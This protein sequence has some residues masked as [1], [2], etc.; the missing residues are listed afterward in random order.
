MLISP[1]S[2]NTV[3]TY[4]DRLKQ[5]GGRSGGQLPEMHKTGRSLG[6]RFAELMDDPMVQMGQTDAVKDFLGIGDGKKG[7]DMSSIDSAIFGSM[8][9]TNVKAL[10]TLTR[11]LGDEQNPFASMFRGMGVPEG[12][13]L[14]MAVTPP[15][16]ASRSTMVSIMD[17]AATAVDGVG[18]TSGRTAFEASQAMQQAEHQAALGRADGSVAT[19]QAGQAQP[20]PH[21]EKTESVD[22]PSHLGAAAD[23]ERTPLGS[24]AALFESG[25][26]GGI[27]AIGYDRRGG[28]SYGKF[29]L[30]SRAGTM[31]AFIR[32]LDSHAPDM[33][34]HLK[35]A[36]RANT[37][38]RFG[39]MPTAWK[40]L[41]ASQPARFEQLQDSFIHSNNFY[42]AFKAVS[43]A[44]Q[45]DDMNPALQEVLFSTAVQHGPTGAVRIFA[46]AFGRTGGYVDGM[47][48]D[49]IRN[50]YRVRQG[51]FDSS[52]SGVQT[53]VRG[54]LGDELRMALS[55]LE[56]TDMA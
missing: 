32:Y 28:T 38:S 53:A 15:P 44:M 9:L 1:I 46:K 8:D 31:D 25:A 23:S 14:R 4:L 56:Q 10:A 33:A 45:L 41:A 18:D 11:V 20:V 42:P 29:Q 6:S 16:V 24:L 22:S 51:Q 13:E 30:S 26:D 3:T 17:Q 5:G 43:R 52:S 27:Q 36:G 47:E 48:A 49:F 35:A 55:M 21:S 34:S 54:R 12:N 50:V 2:M 40:Q 37:G 39:A 19:D 7:D